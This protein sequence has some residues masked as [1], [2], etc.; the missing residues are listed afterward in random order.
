MRLYSENTILIIAENRN[1]Y[2][3]TWG[4]LQGI[5]SSHAGL[6]QN[7]KKSASFIKTENSG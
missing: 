2:F 4:W 7:K 5:W 1:A 6:G 3:H